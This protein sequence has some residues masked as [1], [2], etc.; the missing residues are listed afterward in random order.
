MVQISSLLVVEAAYTSLLSSDDHPGVRWKN[1]SAVT[2]R[3]D[4]ALALSEIQIWEPRRKRN[5]V[6]LGDHAGL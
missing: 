3:T 1:V 4:D 6:P 5:R 2:C